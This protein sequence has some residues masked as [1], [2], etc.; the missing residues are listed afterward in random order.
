L[1][2]TTL[3]AHR[4]FTDNTTVEATVKN[5][6]T[7]RFS[8]A[9]AEARQPRL[10]RETSLVARLSISAIRRELKRHRCK[11]S[12]SR[13]QRNCSAA[14]NAGEAAI[15]EIRREPKASPL[16]VP[17]KVMVSLVVADC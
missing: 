12:T 1:E 10:S 16:K 7:T 3:A 8:R 2:C 4:H 17:E 11:Q 9:I 15:F 6:G 14:K 5:Y 13:S